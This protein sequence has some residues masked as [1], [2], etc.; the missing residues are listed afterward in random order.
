MA[1]VIRCN[2][3]SQELLVIDMLMADDKADFSSVYFLTHSLTYQNSA[4]NAHDCQ[5]KW[6]E[7]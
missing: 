1:A 5:T 6:A 2:D 3:L 4:D 7:T